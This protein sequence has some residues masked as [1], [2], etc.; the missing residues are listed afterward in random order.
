M[1][2][3][4]G[5]WRSTFAEAGVDLYPHQ[6]AEVDLHF[7]LCGGGG[8]AMDSGPSPPILGWGGLRDESSPS[9]LFGALYLIFYF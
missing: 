5:G 4:G 9:P 6:P 8:E 3:K 7:A 2:G 1:K